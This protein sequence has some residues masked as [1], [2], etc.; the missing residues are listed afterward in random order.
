MHCLEEGYLRGEQGCARDASGTFQR[1]A[2]SPSE[3]AIHAIVW[4]LAGIGAI[5]VGIVLVRWAKK[6]GRGVAIVGSTLVLLLGGGLAPERSHQRIEEAR[7]EKG[8]KGAESGDPP[9]KPARRFGFAEPPRGRREPSR[10]R[11]AEPDPG[12]RVVVPFRRPR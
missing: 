8:R 1:L 2:M 3:A 6:G 11:A 7:E 10:G 9:E 5:L 4:V 12:D